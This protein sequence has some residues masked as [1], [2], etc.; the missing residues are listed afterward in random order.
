[1]ARVNFLGFIAGALIIYLVF[2]DAPWWTL[3]AGEAL[4]LQVS[5]F[6]ITM[7]VLNSPVEVPVIYYITLAAKITALAAA[8]AFFVGSAAGGKEWSRRV[9]GFAW[10]KI[11]SIVVGLFIVLA[12][13]S[14]GSTY[15][16]QYLS[17]YLSM[18][19]SYNIPLMGEGHFE[20]TYGSFSISANVLTSFGQNSMIAAAAV[21]LSIVTRI[22]HGKIEFEKAW[23]WE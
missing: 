15:I 7:V 13:I 3:S 18:S 8:A 21:A 2:F 1:V 9:I 19:A 17:Q 23:R 14:Y 16:G 6:N 12:I 22:Y 11:T 20:I 5:P 4:S 10:I